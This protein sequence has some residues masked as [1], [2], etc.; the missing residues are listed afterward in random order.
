VPPYNSSFSSVRYSQI[1]TGKARELILRDV[2]AVYAWY[3]NLNVAEATGSSEAFLSRINSLLESRLSDSFRGKLGFLYIVSVQECGGKL[4]SH[5]MEL[6]EA[7]A[8][9]ASARNQ[10]A[11]ILDTAT[12]LQAPLYVGKTADLRRRIG[13]HLSGESGLVGRFSDAGIPIHSCILRYRYIDA[14]TLETIASAYSPDPT[15]TDVAAEES[16]ARLIEE[17]LTRLSPCSFVR[18]PG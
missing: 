8:N 7:I 12:F 9:N 15:D 14:I 2:P 17:L 13:E 5:N 18:K 10:L 11:A 6:L 4:G 1:A 16:V 3:R